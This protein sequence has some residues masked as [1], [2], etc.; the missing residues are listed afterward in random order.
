MTITEE[1]LQRIVARAV[2]LALTEI[3]GEEEPTEKPSPISTEEKVEVKQF[4][5]E[6]LEEAAHHWDIRQRW[7]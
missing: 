1:E 6:E 5:D 4:S 2:K 7:L 3:K